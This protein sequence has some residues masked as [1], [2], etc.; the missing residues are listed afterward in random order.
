MNKIETLKNGLKVFYA[1]MKGVNTVTIILAVGTGSKYETRGNNGISHFLEHMM[2][3][4]TKRF[5]DSQALMSAIDQLGGEINAGTGKEMTEYYIK[6]DSKKAEV[7]T[8]LIAEMLITSKFEV[9]DFER[10]KGVI[11]EE[12]NM[13]E[14]NPMAY[15]EDVFELCMYGDTPAGR[16][17]AGPKENI[18]NMKR[19]DLVG[20]FE[21]Q[22][23]L[24]NSCLI[25]GGDT[26]K[27]GKAKLEK[28][29]AGYAKKHKVKNFI[30]KETVLQV[31]DKAK[32]RIKFKKTD[33]AHI[34]LGVPTFMSGDLKETLTKMIAVILGGSMSS[35]LFS[36]L[37][38]KRGLAYYVHTQVESSTDCGYI[39]TQA[40]VPVDKV[41]VAIKTILTEYKKIAD[42]LVPAKELQK[43]KDMLNGKIALRLEG[44]D[45]VAN[46]YARQVIMNITQER[47]T[48]KGRKIIT[49]QEYLAAIN[50]ITAKE[51]QAVAKE[52]FQTSKLNLAIIGPYE[53]EEEFKK[54]LRF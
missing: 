17:V 21:N 6:V 48:G 53:K 35:R 52:I 7:A 4:S 19:D 15:A 2:F 1:P 32:C 26:A 37:R 8:E 29:F 45:E 31:Q 11:V 28:I 34:S 24:D 3:K 33:Q 16:D 13:I 10:E 25:I 43:T 54:L 30:S 42:V 12:I 27:L 49:P 38:E 5:K 22:Y 47:E 23:Q 46:W 14:D 18:I 51:I 50:N 36:E 41:D 44:S 20:Y 39:T 40:G 9:A